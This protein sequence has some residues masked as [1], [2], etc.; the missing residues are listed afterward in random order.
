MQLTLDPELQPEL[1]DPNSRLSQ[2]LF[3]EHKNLAKEYLKIE[4]ELAY[5][6]QQRDELLSDPLEGEKRKDYLKKI[7]EKVSFQG[8]CLVDKFMMNLRDSEKNF[9]IKGS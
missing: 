2:Q 4:T 8:H 5:K 7:H 6:T 3:K 9:V 1:P